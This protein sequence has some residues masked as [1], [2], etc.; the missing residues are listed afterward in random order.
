MPYLKRRAYCIFTTFDVTRHIVYRRFGYILQICNNSDR[1]SDTSEPPDATV[2]N[3]DRIEIPGIEPGRTYQFV[4]TALNND[5]YSPTSDPVSLTYES[6][7]KNNHPKISGEL[8]PDKCYALSPLSFKINAVCFDN[9]PL[10]FSLAGPAGSQMQEGGE[11]SSTPTREQFGVSQFTV[12]VKNPSGAQIPS[13]L[14][15]MSSIHP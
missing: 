3:I 11:F 15:L 1:N 6:R 5:S 9:D 13:K 14:Q 10:T 8:L 2:Q 12:Y 7:D 4:V